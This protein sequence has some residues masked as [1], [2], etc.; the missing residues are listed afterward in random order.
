MQM[1]QCPSGHFFDQS[2]HA[3]CPYCNAS[4][5]DIAKTVP[6]GSA[7]QSSPVSPPMPMGSSGDIGSTVPVSRPGAGSVG[8]EFGKTVANASPNSMDY[9]RTVAIIKKEMGIDPVVG[10]LVC[11]E[12]K[13][14]GRDYRM[15]S[16][17]N[18]IGRGEK[19]DICVRGDDTI[20]RENHAIISYDTRDKVYYLSPGEGRSIVRLN[21]KALFSTASLAAYDKIELGNTKFVF[22]PLCGGEF[23]WI[24]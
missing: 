8:V 9:E 20:S 13:E 22:I 23:A 21:E 15:H 10:W 24:D 3:Q 5:A 6:V 18:F 4:S 1:K 11:V 19:M 17:N 16:D 12:G 2:T 14:K 7:A